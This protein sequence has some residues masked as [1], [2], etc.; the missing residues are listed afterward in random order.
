[1]VSIL[2]EYLYFMVW[3]Y[4]INTFLVQF[5]AKNIIISPIFLVWK[6]CEQAQFPQNFHIRKLGEITL[7]YAVVPKL[8]KQNLLERCS[9][10]Y[11]IWILYSLKTNIKQKKSKQ[12]Y[13]SIWC[14]KNYRHVFKLVNAEALW[15]PRQTSWME[16]FAKVVSH[17]H[18]LTIFLKPSILDVWRSSE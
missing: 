6:F 15:K 10:D 9:W 11:L 8:T 16:H 3:N 17:F 1:M 18:P 2:V 13:K 12:F 14:K 5:T 7:F 4:F